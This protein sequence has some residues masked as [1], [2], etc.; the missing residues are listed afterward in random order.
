MPLTI[1]KQ[2]S[3]ERR[4]QTPHERGA[5]GGSAIGNPATCRA[6]NTAVAPRPAEVLHFIAR[7]SRRVAVSVVGGTLVSGGVALLVLPGPGLLVVAIGFAI[8]GTE[9]AWAAIALDRTKRLAGQAGSVARRRAI[10]AGRSTGSALR[11]L[12]RRRPGH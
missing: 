5:H 2:G 8:L 6:V 4:S 1:A 11:S 10:A 9:Y 12:G 7:S 3:R